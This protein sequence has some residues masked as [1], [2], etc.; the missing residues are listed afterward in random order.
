MASPVAATARRAPT[1]ARARDGRC[2][3]G[4]CPR[5]AVRRTVAVAVAVVAVPAE[6]A[7]GIARIVASTTGSDART[8]GSVAESSP[9]RASS[10]N[11]A[12]ITAR[13]SSVGPPLPR[14]YGDR[15]V[16]I[17]GLR[18]PDEV[19]RRERAG[20]GHR[21]ALDR[22][23]E[24]VGDAEPDR[25]PRPSRRWRREVGRCDEPGDLG[26][27][28]RR[29]EAALLL[30]ALDAER[31]AVGGDEVRRRLDVVRVQRRVGEPELRPPSGAGTR[32]RRAGCRTSP[33]R[34]CR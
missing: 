22:A 32:S 24:V 10:R 21:P 20:R 30:P 7:R 27:D 17:P 34:S 16:R 31:R 1:R 6:A 18:E 15:R 26:G 23:L 14:L 3:A 11:P 9:S 4:G 5:P 19:A 13:W 8:S 28:R 29:R 12:S 25:A 33:A 2:H